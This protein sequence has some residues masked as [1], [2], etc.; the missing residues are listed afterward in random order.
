MF[1]RKRKRNYGER[2]KNKKESINKRG[3]KKQKK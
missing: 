1:S 2:H 3:K